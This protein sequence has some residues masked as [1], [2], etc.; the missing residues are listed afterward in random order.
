MFQSVNHIDAVERAESIVQL[1]FRAARGNHETDRQTVAAIARQAQLSPSVVRRFLQ[2]SRRPK[3]VSLTT[4]QRLVDAYRRLL[5]R[6]LDA[7]KTEICRIEAVQRG[8]HDVAGAAALMAEAQALVA[9][10]EAA[11]Q[12]GE[13]TRQRRTG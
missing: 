11:V 7:V 3:D 12:G 1:M 6:Q 5:Q 10:L 4:W 9:R 13:E 2:P 8:G